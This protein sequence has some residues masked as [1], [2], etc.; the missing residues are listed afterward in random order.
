[1]GLTGVLRGLG[2]DPAAVGGLWGAVPCGSVLPATLRG[3]SGNPHFALVSSA[4]PPV[5]LSGFRCWLCASQTAI[6]KHSPCFFNGLLEG[7]DER[8]T[9]HRT[10][11]GALSWA[12]CAALSSTRVLAKPLQSTLMHP[13]NTQFLHKKSYFPSAEHTQRSFC[14]SQNLCAAF[15]T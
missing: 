12:L 1:M 10:E 14:S 5:N 15:L 2:R 11:H 4:P 13:E 3:W 6:A 8:H 7:G 9:S